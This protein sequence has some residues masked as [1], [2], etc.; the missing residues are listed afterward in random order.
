MR[1]GTTK[2]EKRE[3]AQAKAH[4]LGHCPCYV[5]QVEC[6][7]FDFMFDDI[8]RCAGEVENA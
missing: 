3:K 4:E 5:G 6:P 2:Q 8:C 1:N 7:C